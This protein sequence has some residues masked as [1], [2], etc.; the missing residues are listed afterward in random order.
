[1]NTSTS[2]VGKKASLKDFPRIIRILLNMDD[3]DAV[4]LGFHEL[5]KAKRSLYYRLKIY[6]KILIQLCPCIM[7]ILRNRILY[8]YLYFDNENN[9]VGYYVLEY[10]VKEKELWLRQIYVLPEHRG[11]GYGRLFLD[12]IIDFMKE[13]GFQRIWLKVREDKI[14]ARKLYEKYGF[15]MTETHN[16]IATYVYQLASSP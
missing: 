12:K 11:K 7:R 3:K 15:K 6:V 16:G 10:R 14:P 13:K 5:L 9:V 8:Y 2:L 4:M 1:M